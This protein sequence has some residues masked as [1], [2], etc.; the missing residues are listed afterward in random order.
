MIGGN[1]FI[2]SAVCAE[3]F[4]KRKMYI[5]INTL[6]NIHFIKLLQKEV[7]EFF[8]ICLIIPVRHSGITCIPGYRKIIFSDQQRIDIYS[9][10]KAKIKFI[11]SSKHDLDYQHSGC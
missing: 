9:I 10:H 3:C 2:T 6:S 8:L 7:A 4:A 5:K 11:I 1:P